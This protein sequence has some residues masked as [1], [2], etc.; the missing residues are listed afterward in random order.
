M[1]TDIQSL[2]SKIELAK[3]F[4][5]GRGTGPAAVRWSR[6]DWQTT[7]EAKTCDAGLGV[8]SAAGD[9]K[10]GPVGYHL[11]WPRDLTEVAGAFVAVGA[12]ED[13]L[14][15]VGYLWATQNGDG[16]RPQNQWV[17]GKPAWTSNQMGETALAIL[18]MNLMARE[19]VL[20]PNDLKAFWPMAR[21]AAAYI[22][23]SGPSSQEDRWEDARGFTPFTLSA[24]IWSL[25]VASGFSA[26][27]GEPQVAA[28]LKE[29]ADAW[30][31]NIDFRTYVEGTKLAREAGARGYYV[32]TS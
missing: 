22:V 3:Q 5:V 20:E 31:D 10:N 25:L 12:R 11:L 4:A 13:A 17:D 2:A 8:H 14:R 9:E 18:L 16:H 24:L 6:D 32:R 30:Y 19:G 15:I 7:E 26:D 27:N 23:R 28:Y 21:G 29:S 1:R